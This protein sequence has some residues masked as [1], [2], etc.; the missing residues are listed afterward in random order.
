M[1][2]RFFSVGCDEVETGA[3]ELGVGVGSGL[4]SLLQPAMAT[5]ATAT[6]ADFRAKR[7]E[8]LIAVP[9]GRG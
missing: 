3:E 5:A 7:S 6:A 8:F 1:G 2:E 4:V 9:F